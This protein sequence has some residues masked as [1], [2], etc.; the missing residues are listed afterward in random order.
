MID[1]VNKLRDL[2]MKRA[3]MASRLKAYK[4]VLG[5]MVFVRVFL[6]VSD[7]SERA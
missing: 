7:A 1:D 4:H 2:I 3:N 6:N 5:H